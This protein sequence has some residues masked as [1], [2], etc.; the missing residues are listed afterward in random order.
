MQMPPPPAFHD[1]GTAH[2]GLEAPEKLNDPSPKGEAVSDARA[3][4]SPRRLVAVRLSTRSFGDH[5]FGPAPRLAISDAPQAHR[6]SRLAASTS[7]RTVSPVS[8]WG[9]LPSVRSR[10]A[11]DGFPLSLSANPV[12][13]A[14]AD[15]TRSRTGLSTPISEKNTGAPRALSRPRGR[16]ILR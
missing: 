8:L 14:S 11:T 2:A 12:G 1:H 5:P 9:L 10:L 13:K 3:R 4:T 15:S 16:C 6:F 7:I